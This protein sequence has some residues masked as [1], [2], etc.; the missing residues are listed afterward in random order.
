M[1]GAARGCID[2]NPSRRPPARQHP[3]VCA[4]LRAGGISASAWPGTAELQARSLGFASGQ[5]AVLPATAPKFC[6]LLIDDR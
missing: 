3:S 2:G 5:V 6:D 4:R 1:V